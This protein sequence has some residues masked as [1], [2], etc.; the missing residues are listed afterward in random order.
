M[1]ILLSFCFIPIPIFTFLRLNSL[2]GT[3]GSTGLLPG[4][5]LAKKYSKTRPG[6]VCG[7]IRL[8]L[9]PIASRSLCRVCDRILLHR[10][11]PLSYTT[12][13]TETLRKFTSRAVSLQDALN[14][15]DKTVAF[16]FKERE[17]G[18]AQLQNSPISALRACP[19]CGAL[20]QVIEPAEPG[21]YSVK[22][23]AVREYLDFQSSNGAQALKPND[24]SIFESAI[25]RASPELVKAGVTGQDVRTG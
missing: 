25:R 2:V 21:F 9:R 3:S 20:A 18:S 5:K 6:M 15:S 1:G 14:V 4:R 22:R 10:L 8:F 24:D 19:G 13:R 23:K 7:A 11:P 12:F 16:G 17:D